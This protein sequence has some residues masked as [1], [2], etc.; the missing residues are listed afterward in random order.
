VTPFVAWADATL[1][2]TAKSIRRAM[3]QEELKGAAGRRRVPRVEAAHRSRNVHRHRPG[4]LVANPK[5]EI[6][7]WQTYLGENSKYC[8]H[9]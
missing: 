5:I 8:G 9:K 7:N 4:P 6:P 3:M 1:V 2:S